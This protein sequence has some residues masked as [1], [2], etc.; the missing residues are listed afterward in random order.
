MHANRVRTFDDV[1]VHAQKSAD[2]LRHDRD[3]VR[4]VVTHAHHGHDHAGGLPR[5]VDDVGAQEKSVEQ[6]WT[7]F[8]AL[9]VCA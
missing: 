2:L 1:R 5:D 3:V 8:F 7:Q 6:G 4:V 9:I